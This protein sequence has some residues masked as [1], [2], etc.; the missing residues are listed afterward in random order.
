MTRIPSTIQVKG[1]RKVCRIFDYGDSVAYRYTIAFKGYRIPGEELW[2]PYLVAGPAPFY[3]QGFGQRG[4]SKAFVSGKHL[5]K[6]VR[7]ETLPK[8][9]QAFI[10]QSI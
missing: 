1:K 9:V 5:G 4:E 2:Y 10:L 7:F 8:D 6:R 3:P